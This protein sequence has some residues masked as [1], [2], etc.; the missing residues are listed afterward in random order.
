MDGFVWICVSVCLSGRMNGWGNACIRVNLHVCI[1]VHAFL[2]LDTSAKNSNKISS[3]PPP[4]VLKQPYPDWKAGL[5]CSF[6]E[7]DILY[8]VYECYHLGLFGR[9]NVDMKTYM[10]G[11]IQSTKDLQH[12]EDITRYVMHGWVDGWVDILY[13][14]VYLSIYLSINQSI[15]NITKP[16]CTSYRRY[17]YC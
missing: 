3:S 12:H 17:Q 11:M 8:C 15:T 5:L 16:T 13:V 4:Q 2:P 1:H 7:V 6:A 10:K 14:C 9:Q